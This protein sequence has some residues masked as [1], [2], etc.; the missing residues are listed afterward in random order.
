MVPTLE[1]FV[2]EV[3]R[4]AFRRNLGPT[5][6]LAFELMGTPDVSG[7]IQRITLVSYVAP[8]VPPGQNVFLWIDPETLECRKSTNY[9]NIISPVWELVS[10]YA[11]CWIDEIGTSSGGGGA[12]N[13]PA[14]NNG[15]VVV[16]VILARNPVSPMEAVTKQYL[17]SLLTQTNTNLNSTIQTTVTNQVAAIPKPILPAV[18]SIVALRQ[19]DVTNLEDKVG[20]FVE[21]LDY[22]YFYDKQ[23][24]AVDNNIDVVK[25]LVGIGR[26]I[27]LQTNV[28]NDGGIF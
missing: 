3:A 10:D 20:V 4:A 25:P 6:T 8:P 23:S 21:D 27:L 28:V 22:A 1:E 15:N 24:T 12:G 17:D 18:Q 7:N 14:F 9:K 26:W 16:P 13:D 19:L 5:D 2:K 11:S